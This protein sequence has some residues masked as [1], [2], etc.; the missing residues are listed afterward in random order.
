M[1]FT[2][3]LDILNLW[4]SLMEAWTCLWPCLNLS[5][6]V[7]RISWITRKSKRF[8]KLRPEKSNLPPML[9]RSREWSKNGDNSRGLLFRTNSKLLVH[10]KQI[11][12]KLP[13][14]HWHLQVLLQRKIWAIKMLKLFKSKSLNF[15]L[16]KKMALS[17]IRKML[18]MLKKEKLPMLN[19]KMFLIENNRKIL[20]I[21]R[22]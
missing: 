11:S 21:N 19:K 4:H 10:K 8:F 14:Y 5:N 2:V 12:L 18:M 13:E 1:K 20:I 9:K 3:P 15:K 16:W 7:L 17:L 22:K 6:R